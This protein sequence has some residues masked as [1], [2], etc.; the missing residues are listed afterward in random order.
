MN[1]V[2]DNIRRR[3]DKEDLPICRSLGMVRFGPPNGTIA[4][5]D[6]SDE[7]SMDVDECGRVSCIYGVFSND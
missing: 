4:Y 7:S 2:V 3:S 1:N 6:A 5:F